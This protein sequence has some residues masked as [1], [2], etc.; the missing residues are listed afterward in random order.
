VFALFLFCRVD[1]CGCWWQL[2]AVKSFNETVRSWRWNSD[3]SKCWV[4]IHHDAEW[5]CRPRSSYLLGLVPAISYHPSVAHGYIFLDPIQRYPSDSQLD[6]THRS[7]EKYRPNLTMTDLFCGRKSNLRE[8]H[9]CNCLT[10]QLLHI[11]PLKKLQSDRSDRNC[12]V[13]VMV[14]FARTE[15]WTDR[16]SEFRW[17]RISTRP[18]VG[19]MVRPDPW[20]TL[21]WPTARVL[22]VSSVGVSRMFLKSCN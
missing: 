4:L 3:I 19:T 16:H 2:L 21:H 1:S 5:M 15:R 13:E 9:S 17:H 10:S 22:F 12:A 11:V 20:T 6:L 7:Q 14:F 8:K 18:A